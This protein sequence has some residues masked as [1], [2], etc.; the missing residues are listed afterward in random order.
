MSE[1]KNA[2]EDV[3][4]RLGKAEERFCEL[5]DRSFEITQSEENKGKRM[6]KSEESLCELWDTIKRNNLHITGIPEG[7]ER[8]KQAES[9]FKMENFPNLRRDLDIQDDKTHRFPPMF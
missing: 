9:L 7:E 4:S 5:N 2:T 3:S 1:M 8:E 6:K